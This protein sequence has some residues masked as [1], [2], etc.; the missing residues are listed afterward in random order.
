MSSKLQAR[1]TCVNAE[2]LTRRQEA[3]D[4][5]QLSIS[6]QEAERS[7]WR[8]DYNLYH[9]TGAL[10]SFPHVCGSEKK[11]GTE[12]GLVSNGVT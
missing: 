1:F 2:Q 4:I 7:K 3:H 11:K 6:A 9:F 12:S 10:L 8:K 5:G